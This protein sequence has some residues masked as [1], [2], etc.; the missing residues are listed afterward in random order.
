MVDREDNKLVVSFYFNLFQVNSL[1]IVDSG[2]LFSE[3][4]IDENQQ[5]FIYIKVT[6]ANKVF[7]KIRKPSFIKIRH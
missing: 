6:T 2:A 7:I 5:K 3:V 1:F 4:L